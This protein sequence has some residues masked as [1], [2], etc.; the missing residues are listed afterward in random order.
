MNLLHD[1]PV[2][3]PRILLICSA[4]MDADGLCPAIFDE[5]RD[6]D[7]V[8]MLRVPADSD[9]RRHRLAGR[10][11]H[12]REKRLQKIR[13]VKE[14]RAGAPSDEILLDAADVQINDVSELLDSLHSLD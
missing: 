8:D 10:R 13:F 4:A 5:L 2:D 3:L 6:G 12:C 11:D 9:L 1:G 7:A 14:R